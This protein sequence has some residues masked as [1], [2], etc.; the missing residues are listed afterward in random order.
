M[1]PACSY[2]QAALKKEVAS[3]VELDALNIL[4]SRYF[5]ITAQKQRMPYDR[6]LDMTQNLSNGGI[7][8]D[9]YSLYGYTYIDT[10]N[11]MDPQGARS[12]ITIENYLRN[13]AMLTWSNLDPEFRK[14]LISED[15]QM[16]QKLPQ[17]YKI[18]LMPKSQKDL[19]TILLRFA[20]KFIQSPELRQL[21]YKMKVRS[22]WWQES[23]SDTELRD[24]LQ[25]PNG[26]VLPVIVIY[27][28]QGKDKTQKLLDI[29]YQEFGT[30]PGLDLAPRYNE[31]ITSL[32]YV[33][34]GD[35]DY[36]TDDYKQYYE[37]P[38][39]VYYDSNFEGSYH[40]YHLK[41]PGK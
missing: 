2:A 8:A 39:R 37:Q 29:L 30:M 36:K 19:F 40:D 22:Q 16:A 35:G 26:T 32:I 5:S 1:P 20:Q 34:Q 18:H 28:A 24:S 6:S 15:I 17:L 9:T 12:E 14:E 41:N 10:I 31:K 4:A 13:R 27:P 11:G 3:L 7:I 21:I 23:K 38:A 25:K 33:A